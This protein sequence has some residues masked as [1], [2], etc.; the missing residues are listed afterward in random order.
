M[1]RS[2]E[3]CSAD[4][5]TPRALSE[6]SCGEYKG[7]NSPKQIVSAARPQSQVSGS[8]G[9]MV[10]VAAGIVGGDQGIVSAR[11]PRT[12]GCRRIRGRGRSGEAA[13]AQ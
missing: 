9:L 7:S 4:T 3:T 6:T 12:R 13:R 11:D 2:D 1:A 8:M 5:K 10:D